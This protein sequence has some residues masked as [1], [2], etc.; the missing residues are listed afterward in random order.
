[1]KLWLKESKGERI[2]HPEQ[3]HWTCQKKSRGAALGPPGSRPH[4]R[5]FCLNKAWWLFHVP[6]NRMSTHLHSV[7]VLLVYFSAIFTDCILPCFTTIA[8]AFGCRQVYHRA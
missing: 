3:V 8:V 5:N 2:E 1:M 4:T 6:A 7:V